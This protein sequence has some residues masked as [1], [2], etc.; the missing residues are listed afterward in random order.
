MLV[1]ECNYLLY[2]IWLLVTIF[3]A[4]VRSDNSSLE[5]KSRSEGLVNL[6][7]SNKC[8]L[9]S[10]K[11]NWK[12]DPDQWKVLEPLAGACCQPRE[13][14]KT[15]GSNKAQAQVVHISQMMSEV[16]LSPYI[17]KIDQ[18][19]QRIN[20]MIS[21][22]TITSLFLTP[23]DMNTTVWLT[24]K[25]GHSTTILH[26]E[27]V[28]LEEDTT[29]YKTILVP[30]GT[31]SIMLDIQS[32]NRAEICFDGA[33]VYLTDDYSNTSFAINLEIA[34][35]LTWYTML[36]LAFLLP[37]LIFFLGRNSRPFPMPINLLKRYVDNRMN[38]LLFG[39]ASQMIIMAAIDNIEKNNGFQEMLITDSTARDYTQGL[40]LIGRVIVQGL[41]LYPLFLCFE[42]SH[43]FYNCLFGILSSIVLLMYF[44]TQMLE[45]FLKTGLS[46]VLVITMH[47]PVIVFCI[48]LT[49]YFVV[50][51]TAA[52]SIR[53]IPLDR[54]ARDCDL[55]YVKALLKHQKMKLSQTYLKPPS[56]VSCIRRPRSWIE[57]VR[58]KRSRVSHIEV[59][60]IIYYGLLTTGLVILQLMASTIVLLFSYVNDSGLPCTLA[61]FLDGFN[62]EDDTASSNFIDTTDTVNM[63]LRSSAYLSVILGGLACLY[64]ISCI[65]Y[66]FKRDLREIRLGNYHLFQQRRS[67]DTSM[68]QYLRFYG[69]FL[70]NAFFSCFVVIIQLFV[71]MILISA[72]VLMPSFRNTV[73]RWILISMIIPFFISWLT[74]YIIDLVTKLI[75]I[76]PGT[77]FWI[78]RRS[79]FM[80]WS[81]LSV[82]L[83]IPNGITSWFE[84]FLYAFLSIFAFSA[85]IDRSLLH[86]NLRSLDSG[87]SAYLGLVI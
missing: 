83:H 4:V 52:S 56:W 3:A 31:R 10:S 80:H 35:T 87:F 11:T 28:P 19:T 60:D 37:I 78:R 72:I 42:N 45:G 48:I 9:N 57:Y 23:E 62:S 67:T 22:A 13:T 12:F 21:L 16:T 46:R 2:E 79:L 18:E 5:C 24:F 84:R 59:P 73:V 76:V 1:L 61:T 65:P 69:A 30:K 26:Q 53:R 71:I 25:D 34:N 63:A 27:V 49:I 7:R 81:Y 20:V 47:I 54:L 68:A 51:L 50:S 39:I 66:R 85:R 8:D 32:I 58:W 74:A 14:L 38:M 6:L 29:E 86:V 41:V 43:K 55:N 33:L 44:V 77:K 75:F 82:F 64:L 70:G 36:A 40:Y 17:K 15:L